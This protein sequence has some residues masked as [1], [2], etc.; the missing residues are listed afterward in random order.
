[1]QR[2]NKNSPLSDHDLYHMSKYYPGKY[3]PQSTYTPSGEA[4]AA[5][6]LR[7]G[8][9]LNSATKPQNTAAVSLGVFDYT[10]IM[11]CPILSHLA[12]NDA[13]SSINGLQPSGLVVVATSTL[14]E[15]ISVNEFFGTTNAGN[16]PSGLAAHLSMTNVYGYT[17]DANLE[18]FVYASK[19]DCRFVI[20]KANLTG[21]MFQGKLR[22]GQLFS[23]NDTTGAQFIQLDDLIR[24]A[25]TISA[26]Q[27]GFSLQSS[28]VND[29]LLTHTLKAGTDSFTSYLKD[30]D[31]GAEVIDY[32]I[33]Q[34]PAINI[35]T[36]ANSVFSLI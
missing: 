13:N 21:T 3:G 36:G 7:N 19:L 11:F 17:S 26:M 31:L 33:L 16:S 2:V 5:V 22:L 18:S 32:V 28:I 23:S 25:D 12:V 29:Y 34:Q 14:T 15:N 24:G 8:F 35:T 9:S 27:T 4:S 30:V 6:S 20:P 10:L 1:M